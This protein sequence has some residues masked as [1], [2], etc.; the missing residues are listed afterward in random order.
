L[1]L[2]FITETYSVIAAY[3]TNGLNQ[4]MIS[5]IKGLPELE[6]I[7]LAFDNDQAGKAALIK[8][9][10]ELHA[11]F[12]NVLISVLI[13]PCKDVNETAQA[14]EEGIFAQLLAERRDLF[15]STENGPS[16]EKEKPASHQKVQLLPAVDLNTDNPH[17]IS[18]RT[19]FA[20]Y[21]IPG[22][23]SKQA[24]SMKVSLVI[25]CARGKSRTKLDLYEDKQVEKV[26]REVAEKLGLRADQLESD[27]YKLTDLLEKYRDQEL[28]KS[29]SASPHAITVI[30]LTLMEQQQAEVL[31]QDKNL[32]ATL[33]TILGNA[34]IVGEEKNRL[35]LFIIALSYKMPE[36]L[37]AL[38][39]GSSGS[40]KTRLLKQISDCMPSEQVTRL[41]R[42]SDKAL[43]NYPE[44]FFV[45][46][47]L[48]LEDID[49]LPEEAGFAFRELQSNGELTS[50]TSIK[51]DNGQITSG[52]KTVKGPIAS[53]ACTT[54]GEIYEDNMGRVFLIAVDESPEQTRRIVHYQN[55]KAAGDVDS[56]KEQQTRRNLQNFVRTLHPCEVL[57]PFAGQIHLPEEAHKIRRLNDLFQSF[58]KMVT[59]LHQYQRKKDN[60]GRLI[61]EL[62][63]IEIA[64]N[65]LFESIV[66]KVDE[67]DGHC[68]SS[69]NG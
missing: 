50:A 68:G 37:H 44:H 49:G 10:G 8:Y 20:H 12:P 14:H 26:S 33:N 42:V 61:T 53:M 40:G 43:Y 65:I 23:I 19:L 59:I 18:Y 62:A 11:L 24:D 51:L 35:F 55:A 13:L 34:G 69:L 54:R 63:D 48:C 3:G 9:S 58:V 16:I 25:E 28:L 30:P 41:T 52:Q 15:L 22:G 47:H 38:I 4:E 7:I 46:R 67:L 31:A 64:V 36:T 60:R 32:I 17:K 39:Q 21:Y 1:Q 66:L 45:N 5:A 2:S 57:N 29:E 6:E 56:K 27:L